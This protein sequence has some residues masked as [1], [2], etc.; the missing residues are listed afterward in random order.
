MNEFGFM[1][2]SSQLKAGDPILRRL[3]LRW[4]YGR[5][6]AAIQAAGYAEGPDVSEHQGIINWDVMAPQIDFAKI[7]YGY[8]N[9]TPD[10]NL[11]ANYRGAKDHKKPVQSYWY[12]KPSGNAVTH[13]ATYAALLKDYPVDLY[14]AHDEEEDGDLNQTMLDAWLQKYHRNFDEMTGLT[15]DLEEIYTSAGFYNS[16]LP[17]GR[18]PGMPGWAKYYHLWA[19]N[20]TVAAEPLLPNEWSKPNVPKTWLFWQYT[21]KV[22][23]KKYG[24]QSTY[25]DM[26]RYHGTLAQ[27]YS[28]FKLGDV[29]PP[30]PPPPPPEDDFVKELEDVFQALATEQDTLQG[31]M[32][33]FN[34]ILTRMR[35]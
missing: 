13:A 1:G 29:P 18:Y 22:D 3:W 5:I 17:G 26:N 31:I 16:H 8:G 4:Q 7:R 9:K 32:V 14:P 35:G 2:Q 6:Q 12:T 24:C 30:P 33:R 19:A 11:A 10:A 21:S 23:A 27:M 25:L 15:P 34:D 28:F 20:W